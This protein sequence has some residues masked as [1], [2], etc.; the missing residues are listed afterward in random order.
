MCGR[1]G[2]DKID[3]SFF[4]G[5]EACGILVPPRSGIKHARSS[6]EGKVLTTGPPG[7][8]PHPTLFSLKKA[9]KTVKGLPAMRETQVQSWVRKI[10]CRKKWQPTPVLLPGKFHRW[11][12]LVGYSSRGF[13]VGH[14]WATSLS[15]FLKDKVCS[16][17]TDLL[18]ASS[19]QTLRTSR[20]WQLQ[21]LVWEE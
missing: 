6:L 21:N 9:L 20:G 7:K 5:Q 4:F 15:F 19:L 13:R 16:S 3:F 10:P 2:G 17:T 8:S 14:D 18:R 1:R 11:R 12:S